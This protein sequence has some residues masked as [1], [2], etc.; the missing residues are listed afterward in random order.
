[1]AQNVCHCAIAGL[2]Q[3][4]QAKKEFDPDQ[5]FARCRQNQQNPVQKYLSG[6]SEASIAPDFWE[7]DKLV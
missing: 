3:I 5:R 1:M 2:I 7:F 6:L 4:K